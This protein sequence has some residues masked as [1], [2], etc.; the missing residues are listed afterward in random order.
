MIEQYF[1][2]IDYKP[3]KNG[4]FNDGTV[5]HQTQYMYLW[6]TSWLSIIS[7]IYAYNKGHNNLALVPFGVWF[8]SI[9]YWWKPT[10]G[11]RRY[12]DMSIVFTGL[13]Y[14]TIFAYNVKNCKYYFSVIS[15]ACFC[16][17]ISK[18]YYNKGNFWKSALIHSCIHIFGNIANFVLYFLLELYSPKG[19]CLTDDLTLIPPPS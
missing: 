13:T 2:L 1:N 7:A 6:K 10:N 16:Y 14:Q 5:Y 17:P 15:I 3:D 8:S 4:L 18:Y 11:F 12:F 9:L 19:K